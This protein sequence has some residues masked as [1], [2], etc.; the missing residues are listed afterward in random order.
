MKR[1]SLVAI[2][3]LVV[4]FGG[5]VGTASASTPVG[6]CILHTFAPS[7][8]GSTMEGGDSQV[9]SCPGL[10]NISLTVCTQQLV[11][12][13]WQIINST[14]HSATQYGVRYLG[15]A[16]WSVSAVAG[17]YYRTHSHAIVNGVSAIGLSQ[18]VKGT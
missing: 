12:G 5:Y 2:T 17:R 18:G 8:Y 3:S 1:I 9:N 16:A 7:Q 14:C 6:P 10:E 15:L 13:G 11:T 4:C